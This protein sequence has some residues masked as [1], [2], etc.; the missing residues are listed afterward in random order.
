VGV[1]AVPKPSEMVPSVERKRTPTRRRRPRGKNDPGR[2]ERIT[3]AA[4]DVVAANGVEGLTHRAV[5][6]AAGVP[7]GSTTYY[8]ATLDDLLASAVEIAMSET[9]ERL[10]R[11]SK[12]IP[13]ASELVPELTRLLHEVT[14]ASRESLIVEYEL[15]LAALRRPALAP[16]SLAWDAAL[17][18]AL[19]PHTD[20]VTAEALTLIAQAAM[21]RSVIS[22]I[23]V[24]PSQVEPALRRVEQSGV[25]CPPADALIERA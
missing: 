13:T 22:G 10:A 12:E 2:R 6:A 25:P 17:A 24:T 14:S 20:S 5:A 7:L 23:P 9:E 8:F 21:L 18:N 11:W 1:K 16:L 15:Y 3:R 19:A 4:I